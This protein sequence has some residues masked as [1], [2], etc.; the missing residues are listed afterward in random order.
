MV[1]V[2]VRRRRRGGVGWVGVRGF[3]LIRLRYYPLVHGNIMS[4]STLMNNR[5]QV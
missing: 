4:P 3:N 2:V 1:V 5:T